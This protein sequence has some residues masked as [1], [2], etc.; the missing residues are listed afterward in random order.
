[1]RGFI[2][3][4]V[5]ITIFTFENVIGQGNFDSS[6]LR[7]P[8]HGFNSYFY[9][10]SNQ[11][12]IA[13]LASGGMGGLGGIGGGG[14]PFGTGLGTMGGSSPFNSGVGGLN[15]FNWLG[16]LND[17]QGAALPFGK[18]FATQPNVGPVQTV[19]TV[20]TS[21]V[22]TVQT[23]PASQTPLDGQPP[24][25]N[26]NDQA[27]LSTDRFT[28]QDVVKP[29]FG[30]NPFTAQDV[31]PMFNQNPQ[32]GFEEEYSRS[33][34]EELKPVNSSTNPFDQLEVKPESTKMMQS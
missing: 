23:I 32:S 28:G 17:N 21:N 2:L 8:P 20:Q 12:P 22:G 33:G 11:R 24:K 34:F 26:P 6:I 14:N 13:A 30:Q 4:N 25:V 10:T 27:Q 15:G 31:K 5:L 29:T 9:D 16:A 1:M 3:Y 7:A 19:Q 18:P